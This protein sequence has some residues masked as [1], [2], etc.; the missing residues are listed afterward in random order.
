MFGMNGRT[1]MAHHLAERT[2]DMWTDG[3]GSEDFLGEDN[4]IHQ[5]RGAQ[6]AIEGDLVPPVA[7][8]DSLRLRSEKPRRAGVRTTPGSPQNT[9]TTSPTPPGPAK[10]APT[11]RLTRSWS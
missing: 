6:P 5:V 7:D 4:S 10:A 11:A 2:R 8:L 1:V 9:L 3:T